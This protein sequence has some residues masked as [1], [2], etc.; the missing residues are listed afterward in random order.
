[1]SLAVRH[2]T[3]DSHTSFDLEDTSSGDQDLVLIP[4]FMTVAPKSL[5]Q[6][7]ATGYKDGL[8]LKQLPFL[9]TLDL[10]G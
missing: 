7:R 10:V 2:P 6:F 1:M 8:G 9:Q 5:V 4:R 3:R